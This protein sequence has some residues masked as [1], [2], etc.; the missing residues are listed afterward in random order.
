MASSRRCQEN[1]CTVGSQGCG[2]LSQVEEGHSSQSA[3]RRHETAE[4]QQQQFISCEHSK[5]HSV[6][7]MKRVLRGVV[8]AV[9]VLEVAKG[10]SG[11]THCSMAVQTCEEVDCSLV[12]DV[13]SVGSMLC[14]WRKP[15][16]E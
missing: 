1:T 5:H 15:M 10:F 6:L 14:S 3:A 13:Q 9:T 12:S 2:I 7:W 11:D 4:G 8:E 16:S